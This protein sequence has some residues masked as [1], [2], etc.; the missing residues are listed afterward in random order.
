MP[1]QHLRLLVAR[2]QEVNGALQGVWEGPEFSR[3]Q[4][5]C[6]SLLPSPGCSVQLGLGRRWRGG[7]SFF[8]PAAGDLPR[9]MIRW[10]WHMRDCDNC[11]RLCWDCNYFPWQHW[12]CPHFGALAIPSRSA[13]PLVKPR[14][15]RAL[16]WCDA[17]PGRTLLLS[18]L[19]RVDRGLRSDPSLLPD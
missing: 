4:T 6:S 12:K 19:H 15:R 1:A 10:Q 13:S 14:Q 5:G 16:P 18:W 8:L 7:K 9:K 3:D 17:R 11:E 2:V